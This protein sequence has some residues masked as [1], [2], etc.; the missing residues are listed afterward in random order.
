MNSPYST[1]NFNFLIIQFGMFSNGDIQITNI[2][3]ITDP[4]VEKNLDI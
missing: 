1:V 3:K 2:K 4:V